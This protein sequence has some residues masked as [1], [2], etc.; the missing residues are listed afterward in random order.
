[1]LVSSNSKYPQLLVELLVKVIK[2]VAVPLAI[3]VP[4]IW[5]ATLLLN[6]TVTPGSMVRVT[7][8]ATRIFPVTR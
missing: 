7:P 5:I 3:R 4:L 2:L 6:L 8:D 1:M